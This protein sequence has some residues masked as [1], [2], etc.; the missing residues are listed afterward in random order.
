MQRAER[1]ELKMTMSSMWAEVEG[2]V[3]DRPVVFVY[4]DDIRVPPGQKIPI[5]CM[6]PGEETGNF[7]ERLKRLTEMLERINK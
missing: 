2:D 6:S 3:A 7:I 5:A 1:G 4:V